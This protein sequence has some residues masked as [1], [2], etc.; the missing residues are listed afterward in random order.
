REAGLGLPSGARRPVFED[1]LWDFTEVIGLPNQLAKVSRRFDFRA[2]IHPPWRLVAKEQVVAMLAPRHEAVAPL[3]RAYRTPLHLAT[4]FGRLAELSRFF[5]WLTDQGVDGLAELDGDRCEA[6]LAHRRYLLDANNVVV[7]ER[8]PATRRSAV[9]VVVDLVNHRE[10]FS[11]DRVPEG[12]RPWGGAAPSAVAEMVS[13]QGQNKT[14]PL[15]NAVLQPLLAAAAYLVAT[16]GQGAIELFGQVG[17]AD[18]RWSL[19]AGDHVASSRLPA[20]E[21]AQVL[22]DYEQKG[23]PL[24]LLPSHNVAARLAAGWSPDDPLTPIALGLLARQAGFTQFWPKWILDLRGQIE[25][26]LGVVGAERPFGR[27]AATVDRA[28]GEGGTVSWTL[29]LDRP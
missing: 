2:I 9:Q 10:L 29:P 23:E 27:C 6:Y 5:N 18:Q 16:L 14:P 17:E 26:T 3:P 24:P 22:A 12:L 8:S 1:D 19:R 28:D 13:G 15:D 11:T 7:G 20:A 4:V 21:M 25:A